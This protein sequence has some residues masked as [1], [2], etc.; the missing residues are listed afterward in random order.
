MLCRVFF[1]VGQ[2]HPSEAMLTLLRYVQSVPC[3]AGSLSWTVRHWHEASKEVNVHRGYRGMTRRQV[4]ILLNMIC[5]STT[6][7]VG[8][9]GQAV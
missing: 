3:H 4:H 1:A 7:Y 5:F 8:Y 6:T 9:P 2:R